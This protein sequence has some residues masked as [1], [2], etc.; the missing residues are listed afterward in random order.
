[1]TLAVVSMK[2]CYICSFIAVHICKHTRTHLSV[3]GIGGETVLKFALFIFKWLSRLAP[4]YDGFSPCPQMQPFRILYS[5]F[6]IFYQVSERL[7]GLTLRSLPVCYTYINKPNICLDGQG[8]WTVERAD[9]TF[10]MLQISKRKSKLLI[11]A[12]ILLDLQ[13]GESFLC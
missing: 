10:I 5:C 2:Y 6:Y 8:S 3:I 7:A 1:M 13:A 4:L 9:F 11:K 12:Y